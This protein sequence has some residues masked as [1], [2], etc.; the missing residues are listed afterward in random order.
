MPSETISAFQIRLGLNK[1]GGASKLYFIG[2]FSRVEA[3]NGPTPFNGFCNA[4]LEID[5]FVSIY[6]ER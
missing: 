2:R 5:F 4:W 6:K 1:I 3:I